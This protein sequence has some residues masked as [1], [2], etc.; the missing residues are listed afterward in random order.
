MKIYVSA[1]YSADSSEKDLES[2]VGE[3]W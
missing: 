3:E 2:K 1:P